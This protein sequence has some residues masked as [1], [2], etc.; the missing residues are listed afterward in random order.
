MTA[1]SLRDMCQIL[2]DCDDNNASVYPGAPEL[3]DGIDNDCDG[4]IDEGGV[5]ASV[6]SIT[7]QPVSLNVTQPN[8]ATFTVSAT[9]NPAPTYQWRK[10]G[11]N[12]NGATSNSYTLNPTSFAND[13]G[14]QFDVVVSNSQGSV[15][16]PDSNT[17]CLRGFR[18]SDYFFG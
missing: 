8:A 4:Q 12:I 10:N 6:P 17:Y 18:H 15:N 3:C 1:L 11:T 9:G 7:Q 16:K 2:L 13:N 5:C 14:A